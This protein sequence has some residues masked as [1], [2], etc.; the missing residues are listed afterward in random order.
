MKYVENYSDFKQWAYASAHD[1]LNKNQAT[2]N[3]SN[4]FKYRYSLIYYKRNTIIVDNETGKTAISRCNPLDEQDKQIGTGIA[5]AKFQGKIIPK[6]KPSIRIL[7]RVNY[8]NTELFYNNI[9]NAFKCFY[10]NYVLMLKRTFDVNFP[11]LKEDKFKEKYK[12]ELD[13]L[14]N[15]KIRKIELFNDLFIERI[16]I[17]KEGFY[18]ED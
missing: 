7:Y 2:K 13:D 17:E 12:K 3:N 8:G 1:F 16:V 5:W 18:N 15:G 6:V 9:K 14:K 10:N 4:F 11:E